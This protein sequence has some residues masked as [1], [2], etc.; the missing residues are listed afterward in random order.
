MA[1]RKKTH[2]E[3]IVG[4]VGSVYS[5]PDKSQAEETYDRYVEISNSLLGRAGGEEVTLMVDGEIDK[6]HVPTIQLKFLVT[7][8]LTMTYGGEE[9]PQAMKE[10]KAALQAVVAK[11]PGATVVCQGAL[12]GE[13]PQ[14]KWRQEL[15]APG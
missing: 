2:Y 8:P 4:N 13:E 5:G 9:F 10:I 11:I 14:E 7:C 15:P 3:V 6:E 12:G 1:R